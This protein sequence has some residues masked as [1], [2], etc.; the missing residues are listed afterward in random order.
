MRNRVDPARVGPSGD[1]VDRDLIR[2]CR[3]GDRAALEELV[4]LTSARAFRL[5]MRIVGD[6]HEAEDVVQDAYL[7]IFR[8]LPRF[9]EEARFETWMHRIVVNAA[10]NR[11]RSRGRFGELVDGSALDGPAPDRP[12]EQAADRDALERA[13]DRLP[14]GQRIAVIL[15]DVA[16]LSCRDI[17]D[18]LGIE[19]GAVKVRLHRGRKRLKAILDE[20]E[21][22]EM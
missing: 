13:L 8:A 7:R 9:R 14:P 1:G 2:R 3:R 21:A 20:A 18:Q 22:D 12:A 4:L 10:L 11:L 16:D 6:R 19:E 5:A 15:K 17:A